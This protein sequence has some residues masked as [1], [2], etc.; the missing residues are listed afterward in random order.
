M[1]HFWHQLALLN[2]PFLVLA[3]LDGVT[4]FVFREIIA[5]TAKPD[6][7][8]TEFTNTDALVSK[9]YNSTIPR[10][11]YSEKQRYIVAQIW[12]TD[13]KNFYK[14]SVLVKELGF[15][16]I[17]I[18]MGCP[19]RAVMKLGSGASLIQNPILASEII[20]ATKEGASG[21]PISVKT[22][23][24]VDAV[25]TESW[26]RFL[27]EQ[28]L[29]ALTIHGRTAKELSKVPAHWEEIGKA[30]KIRDQISPNTV[31]IGNGDILN[32]EQALQIHTTYRV[33][34]VMIGKGVFMNPWIF[35]KIPQTHT[36]AESLHLLLL[37]TK[38]FSDTYPDTHRFTVMK[39]FF[40]MYVRS[41]YGA[42][43]LK[44]QLME[45]NSFQEVEK[46]INK[47]IK[48]LATV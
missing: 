42:D 45:T 34:G 12:G 38:L 5:Q 9:G 32:M 39:K 18:N 7:L 36:T 4:D 25:V 30:V 43:I 27:L 17:D 29:D 1:A 23:I 19:D 40:K 15:D 10:L 3:P 24:G 35:E 26:I 37:H 16:G 46:V 28:S 14:A 44:K 31:I 20:K 33:D 47:S 8:F 2:K 13:P 21:I 48:S 11:K 41:F 6:V 22:R